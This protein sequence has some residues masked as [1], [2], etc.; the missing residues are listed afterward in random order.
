MAGV[1]PSGGSPAR[2]SFWGFRWCFL[3]RML[4]LVV[5]LLLAGSGGWLF[6]PMVSLAGQQPGRPGLSGRPRWRRLLPV[7]W[8]RLLPRARSGQSVRPLVGWWWCAA[9][10]KP[11]PGDKAGGGLFSSLHSISR[12]AKSSNRKSVEAM[13]TP[14]AV[15]RHHRK[16]SSDSQ[17]TTARRGRRGRVRGP[18]LR[19]GRIHSSVKPAVPIAHLIRS[20]E[21]FGMCAGELG[22]RCS[23]ERGALFQ[24]RQDRKNAH[25]DTS[26][27]ARAYSRVTS[28]SECE[29]KR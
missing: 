3:C 25:V 23:I 14:K 8:R 9:N 5:S 12:R 16:L 11:P 21:L 7:S 24:A 13:A 10:K 22:H 28:G 2:F 18:V 27:S 20:P 19:A 17:R 15:Y 6:V 4:S 26:K 29:S 1:P